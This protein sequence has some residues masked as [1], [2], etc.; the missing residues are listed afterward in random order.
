MKFVKSL[1]KLYS[2]H[3]IVVWYD[4]EQE[5]TKELETLE[6]SGVAVT[7]SILTFY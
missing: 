3:R 7:L 5:F 6:V 1:G 4:P 2:Q